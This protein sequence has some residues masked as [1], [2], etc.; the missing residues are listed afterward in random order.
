MQCMHEIFLYD[1][2]KL[3][4]KDQASVQGYLS[5]LTDKWTEI[6]LE[7]RLD[8]G[9]LDKLKA[10][11]KL[12]EKDRLGKVIS[13][14]LKQKHGKSVPTWKALCSALR[15]RDVCGTQVA[16][17]IERRMGGQFQ[18]DDLSQ[19][20]STFRKVSN[21]KSFHVLILQY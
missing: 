5:I 1:P 20:M 13:S 7:L 21:G 14:W 16:E 4:I 10:R 9:Y 8:P 17:L 3:T 18:L 11:H 19:S 6:G 2:D 15:S 12:S